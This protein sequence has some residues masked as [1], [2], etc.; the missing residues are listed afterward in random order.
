MSWNEFDEMP[1]D[2]GRRKRSFQGDDWTENKRRAVHQKI[3]LRQIDFGLET[4][5]ANGSYTAVEL[6]RM[7]PSEH[8]A[9]AEPTMEPQP[10]YNTCFGV[11]MVQTT[12]DD[13]V[14]ELDGASLEIRINENFVKLYKDD[15]Q[16]VDLLIS[17]ALASLSRQFSVHMTA[18]LVPK[19]LP[20][21]NCVQKGQAN[22]SQIQKQSSDGRQA[23][24]AIHGLFNDKDLIGRH[25]SAAE[26]YL[27]HPTLDEYDQSVEYS[28]PHL[29]LRPGARMPRIQNLSLENEEE[30]KS[31]QIGSAV[32]DEVSQGKIWRIFDL[33][34]GGEVRPHIAPSPRLKSTLQKY[35]YL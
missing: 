15:D 30:E 20:E 10:T 4:E 26:L 1:R 2:E 18:T 28:N 27:Q 12:L 22:K 5:D 21:T 23:R 31:H 35:V 14:P 17:D 3:D 16:L 34:S 24:I 33:A 25:L 29:L 13:A 6:S 8:G 7:F 19:T 11:V 32:L 9:E